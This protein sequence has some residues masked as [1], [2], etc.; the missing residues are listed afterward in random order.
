MDIL[1][2]GNGFDIAHGLKTSYIDFLEYCIEKNKKRLHMTINYGT[3]FI[4]NIWLRHFITTYNNYGKN[5]IDIEKEIY[6]VIVSLNQ[7]LINAS[8]GNFTIFFPSIF[9]IK[10][11]IPIFNF[12]QI[13]SC[14]QKCDYCKYLTNCKFYAPIE[15]NDFSH[16][17]FY[18][19]NY[20]GLI[21]F[22]YD[23]FRDFVELF[24]QYLNEVV[25]KTINF[26]IKYQIP[27]L[28]NSKLNLMNPLLVLNFN[29]TNTL[30]KLY[31]QSIDNRQKAAIRY[32]YVHGK[33]NGNNMTQY[34]DNKTI[35]IPAK[36]NIFRK[37]NQRHKY[38]TIEEYQDLLK[39][40]KISHGNTKR[41]F[42]VVG[43][44]LDASDH[45]ILK[46]IFLA[47]KKA[48]INIYYHDENAQEKLINN[49]TEMIGEEEV[50][51]K[52]RFIHQHDSKRGILIPQREYALQLS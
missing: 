15:N 28:F 16:L 25:M 4:D 5:W 17:Y 45:T 21:N 35:N 29:Y 52:V 49:I 37:H 43:H 48:V 20:Q 51:A 1:I 31:E 39:I 24:E 41:V 11:D 6:R 46:H 44:S 3:I 14:L 47:D 34:F 42:H 27:L 2:L 22:I 30:S 26:E 40:I 18:I 36:F 10:K 12:Y 50:M 9:S 32:F 23:Q 13:L 8:N 33:I 38:N 7:N 19:E